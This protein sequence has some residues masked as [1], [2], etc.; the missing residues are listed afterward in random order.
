M[1]DLQ[2]RVFNCCQD[3]FALQEWVVGEDFLKRSAGAQQLQNVYDPDA[4]AANARASA[5]FVRL[6]GNPLE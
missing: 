1:I 3:I 5:A 6:D 4:L 2:G